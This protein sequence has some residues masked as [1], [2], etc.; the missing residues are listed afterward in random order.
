MHKR[1]LIAYLVSS[2]SMASAA[3]CGHPHALIL[4]PSQPEGLRVNGVGE[5][6]AEP[7]IA[8][9]RMG[10]DLRA[11]TAE[12]AS[13]QAAQRMSTLIAALKQLGIA[14]KDLRTY[15]YSVS[16]EEQQPPTPPAPPP[17]PA[18]G[19][20]TKAE[21]APQPPAAD[22]TPRGFYHVSN[23]LEV[24]VR[25]LKSV[26]RVLQTATSAGANNFWGLSFDLEDDS[27]LV[28]QARAKAVDDA[29]K[30]ATELAKLAGIKLGEIVSIGETEEPGAASPPMYAMRAAAVSDVPIER[31]EITVRYGVQV[32]YAV[33]G[34]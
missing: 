33:H 1:T 34:K 15:N 20:T 31:G 8:R 4:S 13:E 23:T 26:G 10:I 2:L 5:A 19:A 24:T 3:A 14:E 18:R 29:R 25:D 11:A 32:T 22:P 12:Q 28:T 6:S 21:P 27:A 7:D 16:F 30:S 9:S 17:V